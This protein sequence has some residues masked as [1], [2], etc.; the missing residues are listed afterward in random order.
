MQYALQNATLAV[1]LNH[2][3]D[4][5][6]AD[7]TDY[8]RLLRPPPGSFS[9]FGLRG[10]GKTTWTRTEIPDS[11][12]IDLRDERR[13][14]QL[15]AHPSELTRE[16][17]NIPSH[18][19]VVL[20]EVQRAAALVPEIQRVSEATGRRFILLAS[21]LWP[22]RIATSQ[23]ATHFPPRTMFPLVPSELGRDFSLG[24]VLRFGSLP[25]IWEAADPHGA[26]EDYVQEYTRDAIRSETAVRNLPAFFRFLPV[27]ALAHGRV[28]NVSSM[29]RD[30]GAARATVEGYLK[31]L[32]DTLV[33]SFVPAFEPRL[34][35][36]ERRHPK[37]FWTDA[38]VVRA[39]KG[40]LGSVAAEE[41]GP[42]VAGL[43]LTVLRA[44]NE[45]GGVFDDLGY[46]SPGQARATEVD[47]LLRRG[48]EYLAI[49]IDAHTR[50]SKPNLSGLR[51][52]ARLPH[53]V[54]RVLIYVGDLPL[55]TEDG[56]GVWPFDA[57]LEAVASGR[58]WP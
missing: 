32:R 4:K 31:I 16:L 15:L 2:T 42:L 36:R 5:S 1:K 33:V 46:W 30:A 23:L 40:Q 41:R 11:F 37:L 49:A 20:N 45:R 29:A 27:A 8:R 58:L 12:V 24:R 18:L 56:I 51:A 35:V 9:V 55:T 3:D 26:L 38:G 28:V 48:R 25:A 10:A 57:W 13:C 47:F 52:I 50:H 44:H 21:S 53:L 19:A 43:V 39:M 7:A 17:E 6:R 34:R 22:L 54:R 14:R